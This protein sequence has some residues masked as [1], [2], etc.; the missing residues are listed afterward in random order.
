MTRVGA[1][2]K[3]ETLIL[4]RQ[5]AFAQGFGATRRRDK[6]AEKLIVNS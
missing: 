5:A 2:F 6:Q 3:T 4:L 1:S